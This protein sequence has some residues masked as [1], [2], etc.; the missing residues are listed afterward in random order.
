MNEASRPEVFINHAPGETR[1][2]VT[3]TGRLVDLV[4]ARDTET[5]LLGNIYLGRVQKVIAGL[6]AAFVEIG[7]ADAGFLAGNDGQIFNPDTEK[8]KPIKALYKEGDLVVVQVTR[9]PSPGKGA[10][11]TTRLDLAGSNL[12]LTAF[13]P[14]VSISRSITDAGARDHLQAALAENESGEHGLIVRTKAQGVSEER[15]RQEADALFDQIAAIEALQK[16][17]K[18][19]GCLHEVAGPILRYLMGAERASLQRIVVDNRV[20]LKKLA[21]TVPELEDLFELAEDLVALFETYDLDHQV[22]ALF[23]AQAALPSGGSLIIEE[24]AALVAIDVDSGAHQRDSDP[25]AFA[26]AVN[27]E[28]ASEIARQVALR[29]L[30]GQI[31]IDFLPMKR[32]G[33]REKIQETLSAALSGSGKCNIFGFSRLGLLEMTRQRNGESLTA[34]FLSK[35]AAAKTAPS[36]AIEMIRAVLRELDRNPGKML[37]VECGPIIYAVL[38]DEMPGNWQD[39]LERTGP[40]VVLEQTQ[41]LSGTQ[42]DIRVN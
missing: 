23:Q 32:K 12:V 26:V 40:I 3:A 35:S 39:L 29:N 36:I 28:A 25:E 38:A 13:R 20:L 6:N 7:Q 5:N 19:P 21:D 9:E 31:V 18:T 37:T 4:I 22:D 42:F 17:Q 30:S 24:T 15:L 8:P 1:L 11:L 10:K 16:T 2:A 34:R 41:T 14:G 27:Q 33:S